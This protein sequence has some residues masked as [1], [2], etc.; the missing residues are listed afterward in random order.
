M[1]L[2]SFIAKP[3]VRDR[4]KS[5]RPQLPR[6]IDA[7]LKVEPRTKHYMLVG[8][9]FDYLLRFELQRRSPHAIAQRWVAD[10]P[11]WQGNTINIDTGEVT[12]VVES[13]PYVNQIRVSR[14][15]TGTQKFGDSRQNDDWIS[16][17]DTAPLVLS[18]IKEAKR[19][20][21]AYTKSKKPSITRREEIAGYAIRLARLDSVVRTGELDPQ[22]EIAD[23]EDVQD[24]LAL[25][26]IVPFDALLHKQLMLLNPTF[27][28]SSLLVGG[29]D[30]DLITGDMLVDFKTTKKNAMNVA[31][32]D[33]L[34]GYFLLARNQQRSDPQFPEIKKLGLYFCRHGHL[35]VVDTDRW[36]DHP[37]FL[38]IEKWFLNRAREVFGSRKQRT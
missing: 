6:K 15:N 22:F 38:E 26:A 34:L 16:I 36:T 10:A 37:Q 21:A 33:Q 35:W 11:L 9:A 25:L 28:D 32:L 2:T 18:V 17:Y 1:S 20:V 23:P 8:R 13:P 7:S 14:T 19:V 31:D 3:D 5:L 12:W 27:G 30:A 4:I 24:L 29:A